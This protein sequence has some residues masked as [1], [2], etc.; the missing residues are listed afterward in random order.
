ME[1]KSNVAPINED[2]LENLR[3]QFA[4]LNK[5]INNG[6]VTRKY[7]PYVFTEQGI[8]MLSGILRNSIA[9]QV[10]IDIINAF[11][12]MRKFLNDNGQ[13]FQR[14]YT[15]EYRQH[16]NEK[17]FEK[18]FNMLQHE[19]NI[20]QKI[21]FQGQI[22]DSYRIKIVTKTSKNNLRGLICKY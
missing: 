20:K 15:L 12:E 2:D 14:L 5:K 1:N 13:V 21:F 4:T 16:E 3:L 11:V 7:L 6:N 10:S 18:I 8:A 19:E 22:W 17:N 9:V